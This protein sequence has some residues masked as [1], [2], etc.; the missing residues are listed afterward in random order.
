MGTAHRATRLADQLAVL[1]LV[2][3][4]A[5]KQQRLPGVGDGRC[6]PAR[7]RARPAAAGVISAV[8]AARLEAANAR[9]R[10]ADCAALLM[11]PWQAP[12]AQQSAHPLLHGA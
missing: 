8:P 6:S 3:D 11:A 10:A 7:A 12:A 5:G 1:V 9:L 4:P 2:S